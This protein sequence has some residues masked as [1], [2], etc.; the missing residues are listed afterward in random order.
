V[1]VRVAT[2]GDQEVSERILDQVGFHLVPV[3]LAAAGDSRIKP[4][5]SPI[6]LTAGQTDAPPLAS[7]P[8]ARGQESGAGT[9]TAPPPSASEPPLAPPAAPK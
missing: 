5:P 9:Q 2:F 7:A 8:G 3:P 4:T 1:G 6:Q